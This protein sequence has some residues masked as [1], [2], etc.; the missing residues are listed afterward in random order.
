MATMLA[1]PSG[2][3]ACKDSTVLSPAMSPLKVSVI[4]IRTSFGPS[5]ASS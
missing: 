1:E 4:A 3:T 2:R 5:T